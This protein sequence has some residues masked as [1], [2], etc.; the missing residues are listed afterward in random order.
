[1]SVRSIGPACL[2]A[3]LVLI[4]V[5]PVAAQSSSG[6]RFEECASEIRSHADWIAEPD[7]TWSLTIGL[8]AGGALRYVGARHSTDP[9]DPQFVEIVGAWETLR[10]TRAF[11]EGPDRGIA[12]TAE[13]T[14]ERFGESG[15]VR[16][17]AARD[18]VPVSTLE[19]SPFDE[20]AH[21]RERFPEDQVA[22]FY[23]LREASR[24]RERRGMDGP[25]VEAAIAELL[26]R[27]TEMGLLRG[28]VTTVEALDRA[29]R[30]YW[31]EPAEWWKAPAAWFDPLLTSEQTGG[32][33]TND[34]NRASS[35]YRDRHMARLLVEAVEAGERVFAV[36]GRN[37]V[38]LQAPAIVCA[39][40]SGEPSDE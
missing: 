11:F 2:L 33:F 8:D 24:L 20:A 36:V 15:Y 5:V 16:F 30:R 3:M 27:A 9:S 4:A 32:I 26:S 39:L 7:S 21:L 12:A 38:P 29:Y 40:G 28:E 17:L 18:S 19:P 14:I 22:L 13:E 31:S 6:P 10:P 37:H 35:A 23:L 34:V 1:M 25:A